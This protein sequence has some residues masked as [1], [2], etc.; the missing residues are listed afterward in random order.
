M[1]T[2]SRNFQ[3]QAKLSLRLVTAM[4]QPMC[5]YR[6]EREFFSAAINISRILRLAKIEEAIRPK[7]IGAI[8]LALYHGEF[9]M[10]PDVVIENINTKRPCG[11]L[12]IQ[13]YA[14]RSP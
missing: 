6:D 14:P 5:S 13:E 8:I 12:Q 9:S 4:A 2:L 1:D 3:L 7:V 10:A 11:Y